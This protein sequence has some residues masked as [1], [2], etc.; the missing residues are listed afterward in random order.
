[1]TCLSFLGENGLKVE[2]GGVGWM[3]R[4]FV[5]RFAAFVSFLYSLYFWAGVGVR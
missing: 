4:D 2:R 1:M 5:R 3:G